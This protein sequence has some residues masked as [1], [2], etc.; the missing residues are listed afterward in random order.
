MKANEFI[1]RNGWEKAKKLLSIT[2]KMNMRGL[3]FA[4]LEDGDN[5]D[6]EVDELKRLIES[7]DLVISY[8]GLVMAKRQYDCFNNA[9]KSV[10][11]S[12]SRKVL[13]L[14]KAIE[15]VESCQ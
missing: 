7:H 2:S 5:L 8:G 11:V 1:K 6:F 4:S 9:R 13:T 12:Q 10:R 3:V 14:G 15:C